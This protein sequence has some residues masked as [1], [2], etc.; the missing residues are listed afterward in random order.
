MDIGALLHS[1]RFVDARRVQ[2]DVS[3][4]VAAVPSLSS[5][6]LGTSRAS[7]RASASV[8]LD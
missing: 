6:A 8:A 3:T 1:G 2:F 5:L 7:P 4:T